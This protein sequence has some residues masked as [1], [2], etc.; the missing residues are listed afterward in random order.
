MN[1]HFTHQRH[2]TRGMIKST[3]LLWCLLKTIQQVETFP[4]VVCWRHAPSLGL[5]RTLPWN[6]VLYGSSRDVTGILEIPYYDTL[7][8]FL[9][10]PHP[11]QSPSQ[12]IKWCW[13][14]V[15][16]CITSHNYDVINVW[17]YSILCNNHRQRCP[18]RHLKSSSC[19]WR[20]FK[21]TEF[22]L[23][24]ARLINQCAGDK[25]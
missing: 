9:K 18:W 25:H 14:V 8:G 16:M 22:N 4:I 11:C 10:Y 23:F 21:Q 7:P 2:L 1:A 3:N 12:G 17:P 19:V 20:S 13:N 24:R 6:A 5:W 15:G